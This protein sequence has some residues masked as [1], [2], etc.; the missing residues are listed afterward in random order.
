[1]SFSERF[2]YFSRNHQWIIFFIC[3]GDFRKVDELLSSVNLK[4]LSIVFRKFDLGQIYR[5]VDCLSF[6]NFVFFINLLDVHPYLISIFSS[7]GNNR[8]FFWIFIRFY[9]LD[10]YDYSWWK[11]SQKGRSRWLQFL[12][13]YLCNLFFFSPFYLIP[14]FILSD[15]QLTLAAK[16][17]KGDDSF[18]HS[19]FKNHLGGKGFN[20]ELF[21]TYYGRTRLA[22]TLSMFFSW[23]KEENI[24]NLVRLI[25]L[26]FDLFL[27]V[28]F[29][30]FIFSIKYC[31]VFIF[32]IFAFFF[33]LFFFP[34]YIFSKFVRNCTRKLFAFPI[35]LQAV[36]GPSIISVS[37][38]NGRFVFFCICVYFFYP[39][40]KYTWT[41]Y[42]FFI[43]RIN[44]GRERYVVFPHPLFF[45]NIPRYIYT[46][47]EGLSFANRGSFPTFYFRTRIKFY[48]ISGLLSGF[49]YPYYAFAVLFVFFWQ[50]FILRTGNWNSWQALWANYDLV[51]AY[52]ADNLKSVD[53]IA[54]SIFNTRWF[55]KEFILSFKPTVFEISYNDYEFLHE[56]EPFTGWKDILYRFGYFYIHFGVFSGLMWRFNLLNLY[57][58]NKLRVFFFPI[59]WPYYFLFSYSYDGSKPLLLRTIAEFF[60]LP[61]TLGGI[62]L[63]LVFR[64]VFLFIWLFLIVPW[65]AYIVI[66][67]IIYLIT[68][69]YTLTRFFLRA[70]VHTFY[71]FVYLSYE[72]YLSIRL[73]I[74]R[75]KIYINDC[76]YNF[77][78]SFYDFYKFRF[79]SSFINFKPIIRSKLYDVYVSF[80]YFFEYLKKKITEFLLFIFFLF[81][82][83]QR[84]RKRYKK[85]TVKKLPKNIFFY[86]FYFF[87]Y[88]YIMSS[89]IFLV[90]FT[91]VIRLFRL[92][93]RCVF[94][95]LNKFLLLYKNLSLSYIYLRYG[96]KKMKG[97]LYVFFGEVLKFFNY[98]VEIISFLFHFFIRVSVKIFYLF[99]FSR[100][101]P[102]LINYPNI[103]IVWKRNFLNR[104]PYYC[105]IL[106]SLQFFSLACT[107]EVVNIVPLIRFFG[108]II[109]FYVF[110]LLYIVK[111][112][113]P[114]YREDLSY[115]DHRYYY[116]LYYDLYRI[117]FYFLLL[118]IFL[119]LGLFPAAL[120]Y[121]FFAY[122]LGN[123][124]Y[125]LHPEEFFFPPFFLLFF[126]LLFY[127]YL[128]IHKSR[129]FPGSYRRSYGIRRI[130]RR[131]FRVNHDCVP[132]MYLFYFYIIFS[133]LFCLDDS[134]R[135]YYSLFFFFVPTSSFCL[136]F[137]LY[138]KIVVYLNNSY[139][140][141]LNIDHKYWHYLFFNFFIFFIFCLVAFFCL[142][143]FFNFFIFFIF[144]L[145]AFSYIYNW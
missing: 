85:F 98:I 50:E 121:K 124:C 70:L 24:N 102:V 134:I 97:F 103:F 51:F 34:F 84:H 86:I 118:G 101:V 62:F 109:P 106:F 40:F 41:R 82:S 43:R 72:S 126:F 49:V 120:V 116:F 27:T 26:P 29:W 38:L 108:Y 81:S 19:T 42:K 4:T 140:M 20:D 73:S 95:F 136:L 113:L 13:F 105:I 46:F 22:L 87:R 139:D 78:Q 44:K 138:Y 145:V 5:L 23:P 91:V 80:I 30:I 77:R 143:C 67:F 21:V 142:F 64:L 100:D 60:L 39:L 137:V 74:L 1:M 129:Y 144:C 10:F 57:I 59:I 122:L 12:F 36:F 130:F 53:F 54:T 56:V 52:L 112:I 47:F 104:F 35:K 107:H 9:G 28:F 88:V 135:F 32:S 133:V 58:R 119:Y 16:A 37:F 79:I 128:F 141:R 90:M 65:W 93:F 14:F 2:N 76:Y 115:S 123:S 71:F 68:Y 48:L 17:M 132:F 11:K 94:R 99:R 66:L 75:L 6:R 25:F 125:F 18:F 61:F 15:F 63:A 131:F 117:G 69:S 83:E 114:F 45:F 92:F 7:I 55:L 111:L 127:L 33:V 110:F 3:N 31:A 8:T 96:I 89:N